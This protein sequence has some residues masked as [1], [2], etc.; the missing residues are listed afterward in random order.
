MAHGAPLPEKVTLRVSRPLG[1]GI[2]LWSFFWTF[3][4]TAESAT[5]TSTLP[6]AAV[7]S[8]ASEKRR[9]GGDALE[10]LRA[11]AAVA[12]QRVA[13]GEP[14][15]G[16]V[17]GRQRAAAREP[18]ERERLEAREHAL[19]RLLGPLVARLVGDLH[20]IRGERIAAE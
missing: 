15:H 20:E 11:G 13:G 19:A 7:F 1:H 5:R 14:A 9:I 10:H 16:E 8:N 4:E 6:A 12:R 2:S 18:A 3:I 17:G